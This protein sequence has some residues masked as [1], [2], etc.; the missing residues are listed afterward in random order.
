MTTDGGNPCPSHIQL[1]LDLEAAWRRNQGDKNGAKHGRR[2]EEGEEIREMAKSGTISRRQTG[3][4]SV[5]YVLALLIVYYI[6][7]SCLDM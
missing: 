4:K 2:R 3:C 5:F 1:W 7:F 6:E